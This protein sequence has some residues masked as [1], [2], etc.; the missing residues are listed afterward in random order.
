MNKTFGALAIA[1]TLAVAT[2]AVPKPAEA[3][4]IGCYVAGGV[5]AG[6]LI[7]SAAHSRP[8][9]GPAYVAG[10]TCYWQKQKVFNGAFWQWQNVRVC[11]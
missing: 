3:K 10:P 9:Y 5:V 11:Y 4:C 6:A 1:A 2:V 7:A 8:Y